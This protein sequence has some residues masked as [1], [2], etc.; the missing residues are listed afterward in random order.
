[1]GLENI[2]NVTETTS[3]LTERFRNNP[4]F[5]VLVHQVRFPIT[6]SPP[7][8]FFTIE[9]KFFACAAIC[10]DSRNRIPLLRI[11]RFPLRNET[12]D[13]YTWDLPGGRNRENETPL[14]CME[15]ELREELGLIVNSLKPLLKDYYYPENSFGNEKLYLYLATGIK[16]TVDSTPEL[17]GKFEQRWFD[18]DEAINMVFRGEIRSSWTVIG[19]LAAKIRME[20]KKRT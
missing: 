3:V 5:D 12:G 20:E 9:Y 6:G 4:Y 18:F 2:F 11:P 10:I 14:E 17:E 19:L 16:Q 8:D 13:E 1:M 15:R 7:S